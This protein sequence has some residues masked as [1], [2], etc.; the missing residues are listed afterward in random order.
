MAPP[1]MKPIPAKISSRGDAIFWGLVYVCMV[2][3]VTWWD[4]CWV[5]ILS[6]RFGWL[7]MRLMIE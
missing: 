2:V 3:V 6:E 1:V 4:V 7:R 5:R